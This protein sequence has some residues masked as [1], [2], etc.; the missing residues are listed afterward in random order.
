MKNGLKNIG[1]LVV[2]MLYCFVV[3]LYSGL[4]IGSTEI[5]M[6]PVA[7]EQAGYKKT[8]APDSFFH[9]TQSEIAGI[10]VY[11]GK[12]APL[13]NNHY[14]IATGLKAA[15]QVFSHQLLHYKLCSKN[16]LLHLQ[17]TALIFPFHYFW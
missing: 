13:K 12:T 8:V 6:K 5:F 2:L 17:K 9:T 15:E 11:T 3:S 1:L 10:I 7:G 16:W 4:A 14:D